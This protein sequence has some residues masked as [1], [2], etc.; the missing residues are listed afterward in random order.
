MKASKD[1]RTAESCTRLARAIRRCRNPANHGLLCGLIRG[2]RVGGDLPSGPIHRGGY[3]QEKAFPETDA[4]LRRTGVF[5]H[6]T[7]LPSSGIFTMG[8]ALFDGH[9]GG[10]MW[11]SVNTLNKCSGTRANTVFTRAN[12]LFTHETSIC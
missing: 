12:R 6:L 1:R 4:F 8:K 11:T 5:S 3:T 7:N 10:Q 2:D 9:C